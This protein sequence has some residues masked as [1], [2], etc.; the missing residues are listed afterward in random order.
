MYRLAAV[1]LTTA[2]LVP[3]APALAQDASAPA[4]TAE[5]VESTAWTPEPA[6]GYYADNGEWIPPLRNEAPNTDNCPNAERPPKAVSTSERPAP[7]E[8]TPTP[9]PQHYDGPCGVI[10]PEGYEVPD[11]VYASA[12]LVA[13]ADTGKV[14]AM[15]DPHGRYR[16][17]SVIKVL[18]ALV[19]IDELPLDKKVTVSAESAEQE[20]SRAGIG[21]GGTYTVDDLLHGLLMASG[22]D[23]AHALAQELGGD[24]VTLRKV[25]Q[26]AQDLGMRDT[27]VASYSGLDAPGM[28]SS[29]W[30]LGLAYRAAF[31]NPTFAATV[32]T[33][34]YEFPGFGE[35]PSFELWNDNK[36][37]LNDPDGIGGKTGFTD[38]ANHTF[39]GGV[40]HDGRRLFAVVLDTTIGEHRAWGQAQQLLHRAYPIAAG[41]GVASLL[42][43]PSSPTDATDASATE[44]ESAGTAA[45]ASD[46]SDAGENDAENNEPATIPWKSVGIVAGVVVLALVALV[47]SLG[48]RGKRSQRQPR[49]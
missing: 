1:P 2:L 37:Y 24:E 6:D 49:R 11:N 48:S 42:D 26:L 32:D 15:K 8:P 23:T 27:Y 7:G 16:P 35:L 29:A 41:E 31:N 20:G 25:N 14:V 4:E 13:D 43:A 9:L 38:D 46:A 33:Q 28:S 3:A 39:V 47:L 10:A 21:P 17:A 30:D 18:L 45:D 5:T 36:L 12:W 19:A 40:N 22:N 34:S 44:S